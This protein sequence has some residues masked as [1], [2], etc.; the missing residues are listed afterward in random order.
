[1]KTKEISTLVDPAIAAYAEVI[2][3]KN[4]ADAAAREAE[5]AY[6]ASEAE[7]KAEAEYIAA[8]NELIAK[9]CAV[10]A[11]ARCEGCGG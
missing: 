9:A 11:N 6:L 1:M 4:K 8:H 3:V 10:K 7:A 2:A 5:A